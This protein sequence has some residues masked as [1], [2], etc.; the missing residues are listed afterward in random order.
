VGFTVEGKQKISAVI[1]LLGCHEPLR[2]IGQ[3]L[4]DGTPRSYGI[5]Q[6][7]LKL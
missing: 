4:Y 5:T 7:S 3:F 2:D 6:H 1:T